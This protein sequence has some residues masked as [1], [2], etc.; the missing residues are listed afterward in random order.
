MSRQFVPRPVFPNFQV[1][2]SY[3][4]GHHVT[5]IG[6]MREMMN[7]IDLIFEVRDARA[8]LSTRNKLFE[9]ILGAKPRIIVYTKADISA[10]DPKIFDHWH[11]NGDYFVINGKDF[12]QISPLINL[13]KKF[14]PFQASVTGLKTMV[15]G[16]PN[17]GKSTLI[18]SL[19]FSGT[20][21]GKAAKTGSSAGVTR[22]I[23]TLVKI[24]ENPSIMIYDTPGVSFPSITDSTTLLTLSVL[25]CT[26]TTI[27]D[28]LVQADYTLYQMNKIDPTGGMYKRYCEPTNDILRFLTEYCQS[29]GKIAKG[30]YA[31][32]A[33]AA[34]QWLISWRKGNEGK[35]V[36][37]DFTN[38][39]AYKEWEEA[40]L[41]YVPN[42]V[43]PVKY[44]I[45]YKKGQ[46]S[47]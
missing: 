31:D 4:L 17:I 43:K 35:I 25:G 42:N 6:R 20:R 26:N 2:Q 28:P 38:L 11:P 5:A 10:I 24:L 12:T 14:T 29:M 36:Y 3:F 16:M 27:I 33:G 18:N 9:S 15:V 23:P 7:D 40:N 21:R 46:K 30:G 8:P 44:K 32:I 34:N 13:A 47:Q 41:P 45:K 39:N 37:D 1:S 19:R 22:K